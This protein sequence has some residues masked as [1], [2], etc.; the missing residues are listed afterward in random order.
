MIHAG[1]RHVVWMQN[2]ATLEHYD[3]ATG[4]RRRIAANYELLTEEKPRR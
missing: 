1:V 3:I 2:R 4:A